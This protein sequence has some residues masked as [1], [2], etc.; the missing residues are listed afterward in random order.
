MFL[1][2]QLEGMLEEEVTAQ[3]KELSLNSPRSPEENCEKS[4]PG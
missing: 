3:F 2:N 1:D 4:Q